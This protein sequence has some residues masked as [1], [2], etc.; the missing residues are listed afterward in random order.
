MS[1]MATRCLFFICA[2]ALNHTVFGEEINIPHDDMEKFYIDVIGD[3][4][5]GRMPFPTLLIYDHK[6]QTIISKP[7]T[8]KLFGDSFP[9]TFLRHHTDDINVDIP[10]HFPE[11]SKKIDSSRYSVLYFVV[12]PWIMNKS[13]FKEEDFK[14]RSM[15]ETHKDIQLFEFY[16]GKRNE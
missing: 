1:S 13:P 2:L 9:A 15:L 14:I 6:T 4:D 5:G 8:L 11:L 3:T 16:V 10:K 7:K 12:V